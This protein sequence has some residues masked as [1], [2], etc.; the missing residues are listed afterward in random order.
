MS[1]GPGAARLWRPV[2]N[3]LA[4]PGEPLTTREYFYRCD[5]G[6]SGRGRRQTRLSF[7]R[8]QVP[9]DSR[10]QQEDGGDDTF[11]NTTSVEKI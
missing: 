6:P 1:H 4:G 8:L 9:D 2:R 11:L 10:S 5:V 3:L 7:A